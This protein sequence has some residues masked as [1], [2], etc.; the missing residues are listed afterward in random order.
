M[1]HHKYTATPLLF[2]RHPA[3]ESH[4]VFTQTHDIE[5]PFSDYLRSGHDTDSLINEEALFANLHD[6]INTLSRELGVT[7]DAIGT[8]L[9]SLW[10]ALEEGNKSRHRAI[11]LVGFSPTDEKKILETL[12]GVL[13]EWQAHARKNDIPIGLAHQ[14][15]GQTIS[16]IS[17]TEEARIN[18]QHDTLNTIA[19][20]S[21]VGAI[22]GIMLLAHIFNDG[23]IFDP[24]GSLGNEY[25]NDGL[26]LKHITFTEF[27]LL[28]LS[29]L[30]TLALLTK[31]WY[32][33]TWSSPIIRSNQAPCYAE[34]NK[35]ETTLLTG[36]E[37]NTGAFHRAHG[38]ILWVGNDVMSDRACRNLLR[39]GLTEG[40]YETPQGVVPNGFLT[41]ASVSTLKSMGG[42][43]HDGR[44]TIISKP[45]QTRTRQ[46]SAASIE[47]TSSTSSS[48]ARQSSHIP[49]PISNDTP[50][51]YMDN[52]NAVKEKFIIEFRSPY[53]AYLKNPSAEQ[54]TALRKQITTIKQES[55]LV[56]ITGL[57]DIMATLFSNIESR[58]TQ[59]PYFLLL[60][61]PYG[62]AKTT[63]GREVANVLSK[64]IHISHNN[65]YA[66]E[67]QGSTL[68][69][70]NKPSPYMPD[71]KHLELRKI[72]SILAAGTAVMFTIVNSAV[73][74]T[75]NKEGL[76]FQDQ[77]DKLQFAW[78]LLFAWVGLLTLV[79]KHG[80]DVALT[81][82]TPQT[83]ILDVATPNTVAAANEDLTVEKLSGKQI[84][85][86]GYPHNR[87]QFDD[88]LLLQ[89]VGLFAEN[90]DAIST[91][92]KREII[93]SLQSGNTKLP[94]GD[95][96][97]TRS[98][99]LIATTNHHTKSDDS[100]F[101]HHAF[102]TTVPWVDQDDMII[103]ANLIVNT[104][105]H[106]PHWD[107]A[108][109]DTFLDYCRN[110]KTKKAT[111][112]RQILVNIVREIG[113]TAYY[114]QKKSVDSA[115]VSQVWGDRERVLR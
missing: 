111:L 22:I 86:T 108:A 33:D 97:P 40:H 32:I 17:P 46:P 55:P 54:W 80:Y 13:A 83:L 68:V 11:L 100:L 78:M 110:T 51:T 3:P 91:E 106:T 88:A 21:D 63:L 12:K 57:D 85:T 50:T 90:W 114:L 9:L 42:T 61:G 102:P 35:P 18:Q 36:T 62:A 28:V 99:F 8:T 96:V 38:G 2:Y 30:P 70:I 77:L 113:N 7:M 56:L 37:K 81:H 39:T 115:I 89:N 84:S 31:K 92:A 94:T 15:L 66:L 44:F 59:E 19:K 5:N 1:P 74:N 82:D 10:H 72:T 26:I 67:T 20:Y 25:G 65:Y 79:S 104:E 87:Y 43:E 34:E 60:S 64:K 105:P 52:R 24:Q 45:Q 14:L 4:H 112:T 29:L 27:D 93:T 75:Y 107:R 48:T 6:S 58:N 101:T 49:V 73:T 103:V 23:R 41:V 69:C 47:S 71:T 53:V 109:I 76:S 16:A 98:K 95:I